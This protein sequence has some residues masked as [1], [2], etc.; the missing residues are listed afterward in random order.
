MNLTSSTGTW[1][2][3]C[4]QPQHYYVSIDIKD[5]EEKILARVCLSYEQAAKM[6][7]YNGDVECTLE[8]FRDLHGNLTNE[9]IEPPKT[10][11]Q[12]MKERLKQSH[13]SIEKRLEDVK[14]DIYAMVNG[15][16]SGKKNL[17]QLLKDI[18]IIQSHYASNETFVVQQAEEELGT[19]Q[20]NAAGQL[21]LFL[22]SH[23]ANVDKEDLCKMLSVGQPLSIV[24]KSVAPVKDVYQLK[25]REE[26][27]IDE[28]TEL[29]VADQIYFILK[30]LE[31]KQP[32]DKDMLFNCSVI[33]SRS[34]VL[35]K[36]I[37]YQGTT[38]ISLEEAKEYLRFLLTVKDIKDFKTHFWFKKNLEK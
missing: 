9:K 36:Y 1:L 24:D 6:L 28:M 16:K 25:Q 3:G 33:S 7:L 13:A 35:I 23:G 20:N 18:E 12:R 38:K 21:G 19:M 8:K 27:T 26:K 15:E 4:L 17:T 11:H 2:K 32:K 37:S 29:E 31:Q 14:R 34:N 30:N 5:P 22:Q 10:V